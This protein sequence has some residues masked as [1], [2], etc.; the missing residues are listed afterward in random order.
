MIMVMTMMVM[1]IHIIIYYHYN[2]LTCNISS[3][4][5]VKFNGL[6]IAEL[7][8]DSLFWFS[9]FSFFTLEISLS[10]EYFCCTLCN[11]GSVSDIP[12]IFLGD[13]D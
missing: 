4:T 6:K 2:L 13:R 12:E 9:F 8:M 10:L 1:F 5:K 7:L 11:S 3:Y